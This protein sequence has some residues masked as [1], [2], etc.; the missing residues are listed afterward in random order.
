[1][2]MQDGKNCIVAMIY[3]EYK[4]ENEC[5]CGVNELCDYDMMN[6]ICMF[7]VYWMKCDYDMMNMICLFM[8]QDDNGKCKYNDMLDS[9][10]VL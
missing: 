4:H 5:L 3:F 2:F 6:M 10:S 8:W 1:M 7:D 9:I